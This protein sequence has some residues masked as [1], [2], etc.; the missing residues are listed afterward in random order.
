MFSWVTY[1][2]RRLRRER[3]LCALCTITSS[4]PLRFKD[5]IY[6]RFFIRSRING[7]LVT[8]SK[9]VRCLSITLHILEF[10]GKMQSWDRDSKNEQGFFIPP[11][12]E[13]VCYQWTTL[14]PRFTIL[15]FVTQ[16]Q[17]MWF[18][19][20]SP[21]KDWMKKDVLKSAPKSVLCKLNL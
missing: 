17:N 15:N 21:K 11:R 9:F 12:F 10:K 2:R 20:V 4:C 8:P 6:R 7:S 5:R 18:E 1:A 19:K 14:T 3:T 13:P 16:L